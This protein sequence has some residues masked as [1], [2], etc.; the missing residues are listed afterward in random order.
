MK[1][2]QIIPI[3]I[4]IISCISCTDISETNIINDIPLFFENNPANI[5]YIV[6]Q[7]A[8]DST[9]LDDMIIFN[10]GI[11]GINE[12]DAEEGIESM[13]IYSV[14]DS[15]DKIFAQFDGNNRC[16]ILS[17]ENN[18]A[19]INYTEDNTCFII[20]LNSSRVLLSKEF[21]L[22]NNVKNNAYRA[23]G[24]S[25]GK[26]INR[27]LNIIGIKD[28]CENIFK[29]GPLTDKL[30][31]IAVQGTAFIETPNS[32]WQLSLDGSTA[33]LSAGIVAIATPEAVPITLTIEGI[34]AISAYIENKSNE[35]RQAMCEYFLGQCIVE[36]LEA[37]WVSPQKYKIGLVVGGTSTIPNRNEM[38]FV[39]S[40]MNLNQENSIMG[41]VMFKEKINLLLEPSDFDIY[42]KK[43][44][45]IYSKCPKK[46]GKYT[47]TIEVEPGYR[48]KYRAFIMPSYEKIGRDNKTVRRNSQSATYYGEVKSIEELNTQ[49]TD[50]HLF[51][52]TGYR[53]SIRFSVFVETKNYLN[54]DLH[55]GY[56]KNLTIKPGIVIYRD[57]NVQSRVPLI[58]DDDGEGRKII[59]FTAKSDELTSNF[60]NFTAT[61]KEHW[62]I[63]TYI[64]YSDPGNLMWPHE[65]YSPD[66]IP[67]NIVY[68][69]KPSVTF[70]T[71]NYDG[72]N[73]YGDTDLAGYDTYSSFSWDV[74]VS[75]AFFMDVVYD[76]MKGHP[77]FEWN[78]IL[79]KGDSNESPQGNLLYY[80]KGLK[81]DNTYYLYHILLK[82]GN[83]QYST[84]AVEYI[85]GGMYYDN[86][87]II[88]L[89]SLS[90]SNKINSKYSCQVR[91]HSQW[92]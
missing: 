13:V 61:P 91:K 47:T 52:A 28:F 67:L 32:N 66:I 35:V 77:D 60:N 10:N 41:I 59:T 24:I 33:L 76:Y 7:H 69:S 31:D 5:Q 83:Y 75:G 53:D 22:P 16:T 87:R 89:P 30:T 68:D 43:A 58:M 44:E 27:I 2:K 26:I 73:I 42:T 45:I 46:D 86:I 15:S 36:T 37:E 56:H 38:F 72:I 55:K 29:K 17:D 71:C 23:K 40:P 62:G 3:M 64:E 65:I 79:S 78:W 57:K 82:N 85:Y 34:K 84:N 80:N 21:P 12:K 74:K 4:S 90:T 6:Y 9:G 50:Y 25:E 88:D 1:K 49:I 14:F 18:I 63:G 51:S 39:S 11:I 70:V 54:E 19:Y 8:V 92:N 48:Y 20:V 81:Y